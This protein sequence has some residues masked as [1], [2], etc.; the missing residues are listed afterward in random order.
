MSLKGWLIDRLI[1]RQPRLRRFVTR[2]KD[3]DRDR[4]VQLFHTPIRINTIR[5]HGYLR[6]SRLSETSSFHNDEAPVLMS[7]SAILPFA[8]AFI[9]A[10]ANVGVISKI[11]HRLVALRPELEFHAIEADPLTAARLRATLNGTTVRIHNLA[12]AE[13]SGRLR[14]VRGAVSHVSTRDTLAAS[15]HVADNFEIDAVRLDSLPVSGRRIVIKIDVEGQEQSVLCGA[16]KLF[17]DDRVL[18]VYLDG[19]KNSAAIAAFLRGHGFALFDGRTLDPTPG[20]PAYSLL[21]VNLPLNRATPT[22]GG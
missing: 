21:A 2:L 10:G 14:F 5:E 12:L 8:D 7:L 11:L 22:P 15:C 6:A 18:A 1:I 3:G 13:V 17:A 19:H 9:D 16:E 4:D 20:E